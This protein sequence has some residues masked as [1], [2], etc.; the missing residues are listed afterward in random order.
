MWIEL[1]QSSISE[2]FF[3]LDPDTAVELLKAWNLSEEAVSAYILHGTDDMFGLN[4]WLTITQV[5]K[6][7]EVTDD[8][9]DRLS[10]DLPYWHR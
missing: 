5:P 8:D 3:Y 7:S 4:E 9:Y 6:F 1:T 2:N 10:K